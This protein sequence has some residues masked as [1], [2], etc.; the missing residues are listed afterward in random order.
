ML[1]L[2]VGGGAL[3][4]DG[5][6]ETTDELMARAWRQLD[7]HQPA[8]AEA[9]FRSALGQKDLRAKRRALA[10]L[11]VA[12][13]ASRLK[14]EDEAERLLTKLKDD[15]AS[16]PRFRRQIVDKA[17]RY[18]VGA[19]A[20]TFSFHYRQGFSFAQRKL[21]DPSEADV[22][23]K[24]CAGGISFITLEVPGGKIVNLERV[25]RRRG[26]SMKADALFETVVGADPAKL[27]W[28]DT[29]RGA[30]RIPESDVF[31]LRLRD[32]GWVKLAI[33]GRTR[34]SD[35]MTQPAKLR[36]AY[37]PGRPAFGVRG[38][39]DREIGGVLFSREPQATPV[40]I[41]AAQRATAGQERRKRQERTAMLRKVLAQARIKMPDPDKCQE[42]L[43]SRRRFQ[44]YEAC[45]FS[46]RFGIRDD[47]DLKKTRNDWDLQFGNG[48]DVF[49]VNMVGDDRCTLT[50]L[51]K[52][53]W[54]ELAQRRRVEEGQK[55]GAAVMA[56]HCYLV[57]TK[58]T[59][60]DYRSFV[61]V[62]TLVPGM[63][64]KIEWVSL[65]GEELKR[66]PGLKL[67]EGQAAALK[68]L[69]K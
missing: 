54:A 10:R 7:A 56:G 66:S 6:D 44:D 22:I 12:V 36:Y 25:L 17:C 51:G 8:Q 9:T 21:V 18:G 46:F 55:S 33:V 28:R 50:P 16:V 43:F 20:G 4:E 13:C 58:D 48:R 62:A 63:A 29:A 41:A 31:I 24:S 40:E 38:D 59:D 60:A 35:W 5:A 11:G 61:R 26:T 37:R 68:T 57:H 14:R 49:H 1:V 53:D 39:N 42:V 30:S 47:P 23:F 52:L 19:A 45:T 69:L 15:L 3:A 32:G 64:C 34:S 27:R 2:A 65:Q 67:T